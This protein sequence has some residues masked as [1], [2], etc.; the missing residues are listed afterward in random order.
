MRK[1]GSWTEQNCSYER[2]DAGDEK[3]GDGP[4]EEQEQHT[5]GDVSRAKKT[6]KVM[7]PETQTKTAND[8]EKGA[9]EAAINKSERKK[10]IIKRLG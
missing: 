6:P 3:E 10:E 4:P 9:L 7:L 1:E 8:Q 5:K 2:K